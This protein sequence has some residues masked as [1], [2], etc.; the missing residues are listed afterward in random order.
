MAPPFTI[1][2]QLCAADVG[3]SFLLFGT[4]AG[5]PADALRSHTPA[6]RLAFIRE[7]PYLQDLFRG[8]EPQGWTRE[9]WERETDRRLLSQLGRKARELKANGLT[10]I[11]KGAAR[12]GRDDHGRFAPLAGA[13]PPPPPA[14]SPR[15]LCCCR[16]LEAT[17]EPVLKADVLSL[18]IKRSA[19]PAVPVL[20]PI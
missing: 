2:W 15:C 11:P 4:T 14:V 13:P 16:A 10:G 17:I 9:A 1:N 6:S 12:P 5:E 19:A 18:S 7:N 8:L 20:R 3:S